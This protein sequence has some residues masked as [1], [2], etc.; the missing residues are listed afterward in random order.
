M[1]HSPHTLKFNAF[2]VLF[3]YAVLA[4][5]VGAD[6]FNIISENWEVTLTMVFGSIIAGLTSEGGGAVA[7]PVFTKIL[8]VPP[9]EA[10][11][12]SLAIQSVGM[13]AASLC[14]FFMRLPVQKKVILWASL[15]GAIG[16][17]LSSAFIAPLMA[18]KLVKIAFTIMA[19]SLAITLIFINVGH[20]KFRHE[21]IQDFTR[22]HAT[23]FFIT[24]FIGGTM[25]GLIGNG[26]DIITFT[27]MV[28]L[29]RISE[30]ISTPTS[31]VL[32]AVNA[33]IGFAFH[34]FVLNDFSE[35]VQNYWLAAIPVVVIGAP[36]GALLCSYLKKEKIAAVL[37]ALI[38]VE[39]VSTIIIIP[40]SP[41]VMLAALSALILCGLCNYA[42]CLLGNRNNSMHLTGI[43]RAAG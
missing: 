34:V 41:M 1:N 5:T 37:V 9:H 28:L 36:L 16:I 6:I 19:A 26:I 12:F 20:L 31:V 15:G 17:M 7:F 18:P 11:V 30:K 43:A 39:L 38:T 21:K 13:T 22:L 24:G 27:V 29:F 10:K 32:M 23:I 40:M 35:T 2:I 42:L 25:S 3:V 14:I 4:V 8:H 33:V